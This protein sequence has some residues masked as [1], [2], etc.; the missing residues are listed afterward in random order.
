[1]NFCFEQLKWEA[2]TFAFLWPK[3]ISSSRSLF[4]VSHHH[5]TLVSLTV[6]DATTMMII[7]GPDITRHTVLFTVN[8][9]EGVT[10]TSLAV[11]FSLW[12]VTYLE[13]KERSLSVED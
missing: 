11:S 10:R 2:L 7:A 3:R 6:S 13:E 4:F 1:M 5:D 12:S 9:R 8:T